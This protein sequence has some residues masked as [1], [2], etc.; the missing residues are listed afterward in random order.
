MIINV[1]QSCFDCFISDKP[2]YIGLDK[3]NIIG[4]FGTY[5]VHSVPDIEFTKVTQKGQIKMVQQVIN[6]KREYKK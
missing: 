6:E 3:V 2:K 5:E 4:P 1:P